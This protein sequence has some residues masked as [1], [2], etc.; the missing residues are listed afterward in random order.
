MA[1]A[2][3]AI[4]PTVSTPSENVEERRSRE[5]LELEEA[6]WAALSSDRGASFYDDNMADEGLMVFPGVVMNKA[7]ALAAIK[8]AKPWSEH[9]LT[10]V[11]VRLLSGDAA[12]IAYRAT[13]RREGA[14]EYRAMM[15]SVYMRRAGRWLLVLHQQSPT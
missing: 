9:R 7:D 3:V 13:A 8:S 14:A 6:G 5:I 12:L 2:A 4:M 15:T 10:D 11:A 1:L